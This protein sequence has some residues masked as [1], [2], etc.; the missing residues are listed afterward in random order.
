MSSLS[1]SVSPFKFDV[2]TVIAR[3]DRM[4]PLTEAK[5]VRTGNPDDWIYS[6]ANGGLGNSS[7]SS[8][9]AQ[10]PE[11]ES[12]GQQILAWKGKIRVIDPDAVR[13]LFFF[14]LSSSRFA[15]SYLTS[16]LPCSLIPFSLPSSFILNL[17]PS[18]LY[19]R[20]SS[21]LNISLSLSL[22]HLLAS[23]PSVF[24]YVSLF[25]ISIAS[26]FS[27]RSGELV[28]GVQYKERL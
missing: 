25:P 8:N 6:V 9:S 15:F 20:T 27:T 3:M 12:A 11:G 18:Q 14:L 21:S 26:Y 28:I 23:T 4:N 7:S 1:N 5:W 10:L 19:F 17:P 24:H 22:L 13:L 16:L 2:I